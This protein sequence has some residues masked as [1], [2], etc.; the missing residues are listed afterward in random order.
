[1]Q[2]QQ[3]PQTSARRPSAGTC[4]GASCEQGRPPKYDTCRY[5]VS[6]KKNTKDRHPISVLR[7]QGLGLLQVSLRSV[8]V[9]RLPYKRIKE[10]RFGAPRGNDRSL[11]A[12]LRIDQVRYILEGHRPRLTPRPTSFASYTP[13]PITLICQ[14][15]PPSKASSTNPDL[16]VLIRQHAV[17][18][19]FRRLHWPRCRFAPALGRHCVF[20]SVATQSE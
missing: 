6:P 9:T 13:L 5:L 11:R 12:G 18:H 10:R 7:R 8:A 19:C 15:S 3:K 1:M 16:S 2:G 14:S 20:S 4:I 17:D